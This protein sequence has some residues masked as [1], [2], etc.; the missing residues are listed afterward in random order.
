MK[1][2]AILGAVLA[3]TAASAANAQSKPQ[4]NPAGGPIKQSGYCWVATTLE[5]AGF[6]DRC[7][8]SGR[9]VS[10]RGR[11]NQFPTY[12]GAGGDAGGD[13]NR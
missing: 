13:G 12:G 8:S 6:W 10:L 7:D 11:D 9:A 5:G 2:L 1:S 3:V 4:G